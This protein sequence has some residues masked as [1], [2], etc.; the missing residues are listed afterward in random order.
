MRYKC[1]NCFV[2]TLFLTQYDIFEKKNKIKLYLIASN[3]ILKV[4]FLIL[5]MD[6]TYYELQKFLFLNEQISLI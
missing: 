1:A 6:V 3:Y 4:I 2:I 5:V